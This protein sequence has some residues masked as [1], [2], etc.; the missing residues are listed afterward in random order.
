M[1]GTY[2]SLT[3]FNPIIEQQ[4]EKQIQSVS[5]EQLKAVWCSKFPIQPH[6]SVRMCKKKNE[7]KYLENMDSVLYSSEIHQADDLEWV[8]LQDV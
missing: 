8:V 1:N 2:N 3:G 5:V 6:I 7:A 4:I